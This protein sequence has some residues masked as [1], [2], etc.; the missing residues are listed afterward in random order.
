MEAVIDRY[1]FLY[2]IMKL[3]TLIIVF[4]ILNWLVLVHERQSNFIGFF[5][6]VISK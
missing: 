5:C 2:M 6:P 4:S 3:V 1:Y